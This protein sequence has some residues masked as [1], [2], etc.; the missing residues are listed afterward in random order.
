MSYSRKTWEPTLKEKTINTPWCVIDALKNKSNRILPVTDEG[1]DSGRRWE[2]HGAI[3]SDAL[4]RSLS[5]SGW[6]LNPPVHLEIITWWGKGQR[7]E[8]RKLFYQWDPYP[9]W[10]PLLHLSARSRLVSDT[11]CKNDPKQYFRCQPKEKKPYL[12]TNDTE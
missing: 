2:L 1:E 12:V 8:C 4:W 7:A 10:C 9:Q 6:W 3:P 11:L 5:T